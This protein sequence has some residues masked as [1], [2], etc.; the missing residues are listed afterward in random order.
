MFLHRIRH[1]SRRL[2]PGH[3]GGAWRLDGSFFETRLFGR[4]GIVDAFAPTSEHG[5]PPSVLQCELQPLG[6]R[7]ISLDRLQGSN[8]Y[9]AIFAPPSV[10]KRMRP[11]A[12]LPVQ[13]A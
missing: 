1:I 3:H 8:A 6:Y 4:V 5:T 12:M 7:E 2:C 10:C 11:E 9:L 13:Y